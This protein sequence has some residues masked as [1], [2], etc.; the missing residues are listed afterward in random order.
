MLCYRCQHRVQYLES[1]DE[2]F[3]HSPRFECGLITESKSSCYMFEPVKPVIVKK[4]KGDK[5]LLNPGYMGARFDYVKEADG[6]LEIKK[7]KGGY[8][9]KWV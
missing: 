4:Q 9:L 5:R 8:Q 2:T 7:V 1:L 3:P 6:K